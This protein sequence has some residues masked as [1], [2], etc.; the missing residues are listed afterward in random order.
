MT[1]INIPV[2]WFSIGFDWTWMLL[3]EDV[4]QGIVYAMLWSF[5][6]IF[7]GEHVKDKNDQTWLSGY[8]KW[9]GPI[10]VGSFCLF[11]FLIYE[12]GVQLKN[13]LYGFWTTDVGTELALTAF[14][15]IAS[16]CLCLY[17]L[18]LCFLVFKVFQ[19]FHGKPLSVPPIKT[20]RIQ[21]QELNIGF[22]FFMVITLIWAA[23]T[24]IIFIVRLVA[25]GHWNWGNLFTGYMNGAFFTGIYA[26]WN[27]CLRS[28][29]SVCA[30]T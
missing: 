25:E 4:R 24:I 23:M 16:I 19:N 6:I 10:A 5:W 26:M 3:F 27:L 18:F 13:P 2:E 9:V 20:C 29:L 15:T 1:F 8:W 22:K 7:C 14:I 17:F 11:I 28:S 12:R 21:Y 30:F